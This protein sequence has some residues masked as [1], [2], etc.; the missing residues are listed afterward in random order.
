MAT[1]QELNATLPRIDIRGKEYVNV[2]A[3]IQGFWQLYPEG[4]II[5]ELLDD[6][7]KRCVFK[8]TIK[9]AN[10]K[11]LSVGHAYEI[12]GRGV[13]ATSYIENAETSAVGRALGILG[14]GSTESIASAEEVQNAQ[15]QQQESKYKK[16]I[17]QQ[18]QQ[19]RG[20]PEW[21][22]MLATMAQVVAITGLTREEV[23]DKYGKQ[24][25]ENDAELSKTTTADLLRL[26]DEHEGN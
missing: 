7:G 19:E 22:E 15:T 17:R 10:G 1:K 3:R 16:P 21:R 13:N 26:I 11:V 5:P 12:Q 8:A 6:D 2:A 14:I 9:D 18:A 20:C 25:D 24:V 23:W 4:A